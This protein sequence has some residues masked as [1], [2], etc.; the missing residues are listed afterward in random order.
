MQH[1]LEQLNE[2]IVEHNTHRKHFERTP[3]ELSHQIREEAQELVDEVNRSLVTGEVF[4]VVGEVGDLYILL[5]Q[6]CSQLGINPIHAFEMKAIRGEMKYGDWT[7]NNGYTQEE[8]IRKSKER[9]EAMGGDLKYSE[10]Y[11]DLIADV[12]DEN[13]VR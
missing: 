1:T 4:N 7:M 6:F 12:D 13:E 11:L 8:A 2:Q 5:A 9:W 10:V 3:E